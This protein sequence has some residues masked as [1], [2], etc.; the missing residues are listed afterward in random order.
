MVVPV[1]PVATLELESVPP[2]AVR[3]TVTFADWA[4]ASFAVTVTVAVEPGAPLNGFTAT[5]SVPARL[6]RRCCYVN[7]NCMWRIISIDDERI[8]P[9]LAR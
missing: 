2:V 8:C 4:L 3:L 7:G 6:R 9:C 1:V 5:V